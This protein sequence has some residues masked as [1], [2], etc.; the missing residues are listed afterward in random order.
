MATF[1]L[2]HGSFLG[3]WSWRRIVPLLR[4][5]GHDVTAPSLT[6]TGERVHLANKA[7]NLTTHITDVVNHL[8]Y[9]DLTDVIL[10]GWS[11]GGMVIA[12]VADRAPE[13]I[14]QLVYLDGG[15]PADGQ[16]L[17]DA[18]EFDEAARAEEWAGTEA[19]GTPGFNPPPTDWIREHAP[20]GIDPEWIAS[21]LTAHP[22]AVDMEPVQLQNP[23]AA[24]I[25]RAFILCTADKDEPWPM[26]DRLRADPTWRVLDLDATHLAP[27]SAP[28]LVADALLSLTTPE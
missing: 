27:L 2:V 14:G 19:A 9:E 6:G 25:Q 20:P 23:A 13:R 16:S 4:A 11:S 8:F 15:V 24:S 7:V 10:V 12:G 26:V 3:S 28:E 22:V 17:Y 1:V 21:R 5:A 18:Y